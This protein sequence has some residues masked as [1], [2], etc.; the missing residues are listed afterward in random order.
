[1]IA[2]YV[3]NFEVLLAWL[4][5]EIDRAIHNIINNHMVAAAV[6]KMSCGKCIYFSCQAPLGATYIM[7]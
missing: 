2:F 6:K 3:L 1:M 4:E 7:F 5:T